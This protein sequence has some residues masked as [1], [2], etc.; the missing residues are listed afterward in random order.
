MLSPTP[1]EQESQQVTVWKKYNP[2]TKRFEHNHIEGGHAEGDKPASKHPEQSYWHMYDWQ[3]IH[4]VM[5]DGVV[6]ESQQGEDLLTPC[7]KP[8]CQNEYCEVCIEQ[9]IESLEQTLEDIRSHRQDRMRE[10]RESGALNGT[11]REE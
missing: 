10:I 7:G 2:K 5:V 1:Q 3:K 4:T 9:Q 6:Q 8:K 11:G